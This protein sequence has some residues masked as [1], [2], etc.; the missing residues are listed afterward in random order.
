MLREFEKE[1]G[2]VQCRELIQLNLMDPADQKKFEN[3]GL[4]QEMRRLRGPQ[5][6]NIRRIMKEK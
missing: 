3:L 1:F 2:T 5:A 6:E 4:S